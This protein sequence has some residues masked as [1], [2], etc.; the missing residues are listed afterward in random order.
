MTGGLVS[1][2]VTVDNL[3]NSETPEFE[4]V[5]HFPV[6]IVAVSTTAEAITSD[7]QIR[8]QNAGSDLVASIDFTVAKIDHTLVAAQQDVARGALINVL[9]SADAGDT[10]TGATCTITG[11]ATG[12]V[13]EDPAND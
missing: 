4:I 2:V 5:A 12:H 13:S 6:R 11:Y 8:V 7:P 10:A 1:W 3:A 9:F